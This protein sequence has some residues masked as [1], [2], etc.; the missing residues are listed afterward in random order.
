VEWD[1]GVPA[2]S[3]PPDPNREDTGANNDRSDNVCLSPLGLDATGKT[4][5]D[6]EAGDRS[7]EEDCT[8]DIELPEEVG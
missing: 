8:D 2:C 1:Q 7:N 6:Q 4:E 3:F 5:G